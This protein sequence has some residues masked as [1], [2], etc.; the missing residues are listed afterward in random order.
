MF[1]GTFTK[2]KLLCFIGDVFVAFWGKLEFFGF[3]VGGF[4]FFAV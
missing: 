4:M 1:D 3:L 2:M